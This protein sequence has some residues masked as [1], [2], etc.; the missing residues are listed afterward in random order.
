MWPVSVQLPKDFPNR[1]VLFIRD[2]KGL[3]VVYG[4]LYFY[5]SN[6]I[7][8]KRKYEYK[9]T[10]IEMYFDKGYT[11]LSPKGRGINKKGTCI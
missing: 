7:L 11:G 10:G 5:N 4:A 6:P 2:I 9:E 3:T 8:H 1:Y